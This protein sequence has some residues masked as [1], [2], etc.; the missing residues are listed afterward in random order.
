M[1]MVVQ[2]YAAA[3]TPASASLALQDSP[4]QMTTGWTTVFVYWTTVWIPLDLRCGSDA[5]P[6]ATPP[7]G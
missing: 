3:T 4:T 7:T 6:G 1:L 2:L 5:S